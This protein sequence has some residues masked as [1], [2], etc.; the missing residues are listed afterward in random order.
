MQL[1]LQRIPHDFRHVLRQP[2]DRRDALQRGARMGL[3][4][5]VELPPAVEATRDA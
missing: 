1:S 3:S 4:A 5:G 2:L